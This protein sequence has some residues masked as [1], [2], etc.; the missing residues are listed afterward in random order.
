MDMKWLIGGCLLLG[1]AL[2]PVL[3]WDDEGHMIV[4]AAAYDRLTPQTK[5]RVAQLLALNKYP[6]DGD[7][8]AKPADQAKAAFMMAA[9][10]PDA[11]KHSTG[12]RNDGDDPTRA[13]DPG[14]NSGFDDKFMHRYWHYID[15]PFSTDGTPV[16]QPPEINAQ[17]RIGLFRQVLASDAPDPVKAFDLVWLLHLVGDVHQPLH[18]TS[19]FTRDA[20]PKE[21]D[22]GG[23]E[24]KLCVDPC[25]EELHAFWDDVLGTSKKVSAAIDEAR[26]LPQ[27]NASL[28]AQSSEVA[29]VKESFQVA[30]ESVYQPPIG[31][32]NGP[33]TLTATYK[34]DAKRIA[35][36]R[37]AL[38]GIRLANLLN[39]ELK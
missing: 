18:A 12:F 24:V 25:K 7:N 27:P 15:K 39:T 36:E 17:T 31:E 6:T 37:V 14:R 30:R 23:N 33:F 11:I 20:D 21:G 26:Q 8:D 19:R 32:G 22:R 28:P 13:P 4:A 2:Q 16:V 29:W 5:T 10:S 35:R 9:T 34:A 3:A 38:A 1:S